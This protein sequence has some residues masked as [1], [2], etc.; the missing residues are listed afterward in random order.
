MERIETI[1]ISEF[2]QSIVNMTNEGKHLVNSYNIGTLYVAE[3][4]QIPELLA[5]VVVQESKRKAKK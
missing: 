5:P 4:E 2:A 3:F 1:S